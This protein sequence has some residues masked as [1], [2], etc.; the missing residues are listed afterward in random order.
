[1]KKTIV[2]AAVAAVLSTGAFAQNVVL[3]GLIDAYAGSLQ[4]SGDKR[5]G[6]VNSGGMTTATCTP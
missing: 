3:S 6:V 1:M 2:A 4:Y 5:T